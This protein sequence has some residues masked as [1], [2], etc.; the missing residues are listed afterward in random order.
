M[1]ASVSGSVLTNP[2]RF[3]AMPQMTPPVRTN[4]F[5][6]TAAFLTTVFFFASV[7]VEAF[8]VSVFFALVPVVLV[9]F[10]FRS[11]FP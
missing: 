10:F 5:F 1:V 4:F 3:L 2:G 7:F 6:W 9:I 11:F 8:F